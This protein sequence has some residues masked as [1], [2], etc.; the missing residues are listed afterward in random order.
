MVVKFFSSFVDWGNQS[1]VPNI[2]EDGR[3]EDDF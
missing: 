2:G 1:L 3:A